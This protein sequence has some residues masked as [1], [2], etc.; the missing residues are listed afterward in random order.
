[1][2]RRVEPLLD[3]SVGQLQGALDGVEQ[4]AHAVLPYAVV[5]IVAALAGVLAIALWLR[6]RAAAANRDALHLVTSEIGRLSVDPA[7]LELVRRIK[8]TGHGTRAGAALAA[9]LRAHPLI[10][11]TLPPP[12]APGVPRDPRDR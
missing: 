4:R 9:H 7:V 5:A 2:S 6:Q 8:A 12:S 10:K 3:R 11:V 1:V